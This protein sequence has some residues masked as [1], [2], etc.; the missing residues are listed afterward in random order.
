MRIVADLPIQITFHEL[1]PSPAIEE[2]IHKKAQ[3]LWRHFSRIVSCKVVVGK[4]HR[5]KQQ[6]ER[7]EIRI[8]IAVP[9]GEVVV[10]RQPGDDFGHTDVRIAIDDAF[11]AADRQIKEYARKLRRNVK[12]HD[13]PPHGRVVRIDP[14]RGEAHLKLADVLHAASRTREALDHLRAAA[15][16]FRAKDKP[17]QRLDALKRLLE[18]TPEN[19]RSPVRVQ[20][21]DAL[22]AAGDNAMAL[23]IL[24]EESRLLEA[25]GALEIMGNRGSTRSA[26][27]GLLLNV[28][29]RIAQ[30]DPGD[31]DSLLRLGKYQLAARPARAI[32]TLQAVLKLD[33]K[34]VPAL[35]LLDH[36]FLAVGQFDKSAITFEEIRVLDPNAYR[37]NPIWAEEEK[38]VAPV[39]AEIDASS[40]HNLDEAR[41]KARILIQARPGSI[42]AR[43]KMAELFARTANLD[44]AV[45]EITAAVRLA[46]E[47]GDVP[48]A[49]E[50]LQ[51]GLRLAPNHPGLRESCVRVTEL[52]Q[53][54]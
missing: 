52:L 37:A 17:K 50:V 20:I 42:P 26:T 31:V 40:Q 24:R 47:A 51:E 23:R 53:I 46:L 22:S 35:K 34:N 54:L 12:S 2:I 43:L 36:A 7:F 13:G 15:D 3:K 38:Q 4:P 19:E 6:G 25:V 14:T 9:N 39:L 29:E 45:G 18:R 16:A 27:Y 32:A 21:A 33:R 30:L 41:D 44:S 28:L 11:R 49:R 5:H 1:D 48:H 8:F 10:D